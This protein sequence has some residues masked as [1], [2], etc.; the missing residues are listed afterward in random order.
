VSLFGETEERPDLTLLETLTGLERYHQ[1]RHYV[2]FRRVVLK[3]GYPGFRSQICQ[4][5]ETSIRLPP[6]RSRW[7]IG[8]PLK[9]SRSPCGYRRSDAVYNYSDLLNPACESF[10]EIEIGTG[11]SV[12]VDRKLIHG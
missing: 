7:V 12:R 10:K 3:S 4:T 1:L 5:G 9:K 6:V 2:F 11:E 8:R